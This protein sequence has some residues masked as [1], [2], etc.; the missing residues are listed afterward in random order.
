MGLSVSKV[1]DCNQR[2]LW[3][4]IDWV[5]AAQ[6]HRWLLTPYDV[7]HATQASFLASGELWGIAS[8]VHEEGRS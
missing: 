3:V 2:R 7:Y 1:D 8:M 6:R 4:V 5:L